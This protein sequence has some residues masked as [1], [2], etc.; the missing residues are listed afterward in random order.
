M[1]VEI[2]WRNFG[3]CTKAIFTNLMNITKEKQRYLESKDKLTKALKEMSDLY[4][5]KNEFFGGSKPNF[6]DFY[7]LAHLKTKW[8]S[9]YF[10]AYLE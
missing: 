2:L 3:K 5:K 6:I 10:K 9:R 7:L 8:Q 4:L 1:L